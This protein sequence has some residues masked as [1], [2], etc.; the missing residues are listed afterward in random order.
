[1]WNCAFRWFYA[2]TAVIFGPVSLKLGQL[3]WVS[4]SCYETGFETTLQKYKKLVLAGYY[5]LC[6]F[7][8]HT[9]NCSGFRRKSQKFYLL[10]FL[11]RVSPSVNRLIR[12]TFEKF[13][14]NLQRKKKHVPRGILVKLISN[15]FTG[16]KTDFFLPKLQI[17]HENHDTNRLFWNS[18]AFCSKKNF[19]AKILNNFFWILQGYVAFKTQMKLAAISD[20]FQKTA[21]NS[22]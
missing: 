20:R 4:G 13:I 18:N 10:S 15:F 12:G 8:S 6:L 21:W 7:R 2:K 3:F 16:F 22:K 17:W 14:R 11:V 19:L 5:G 1:M 9:K